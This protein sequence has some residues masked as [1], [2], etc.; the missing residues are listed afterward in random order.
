MIFEGKQNLEILDFVI[1]EIDKFVGERYTNEI[2]G[3]PKAIS[4]NLEEYQVENPWIRGVKFSQK[5]IEG[6]DLRG[7]PGKYTS[8]ECHDIYAEYEQ[9][10]ND[11]RSKILMITNTSNTVDVKLQDIVEKISKYES[12]NESKWPRLK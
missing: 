4:K 2:I 6:L 12:I 9:Y 11:Y 3:I 5:N 8:Q 1:T 7:V 10:M